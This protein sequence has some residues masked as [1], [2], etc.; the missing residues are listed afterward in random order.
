MLKAEVSQA[1]EG[2]SD[3]EI[4][5]QLET[6][7]S[8]VYRVSATHMGRSAG[9][10]Q[11]EVTIAIAPRLARISGAFTGSD[12]ALVSIASGWPLSIVIDHSRRS[13]P[14]FVYGRN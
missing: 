11:D 7:A 4:I 1:G 3:G 12:A 13:V 14:A 2:L 6:S 5:E 10:G 9:E 8:M